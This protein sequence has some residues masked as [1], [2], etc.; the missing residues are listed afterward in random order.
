IQSFND[1]MPYDQ[2]I[3]EQLAGDLLPDATQDQRLA[4]AFN[5]L[6]RQTNEGGSVLE[7]FR[8]AYVSDRTETFGTAFL[9]LT[10][11]CARCHDHKFDPVSQENYYQLS[12]F[13]N[14][15]D[16]SGMY[17]HF[18]KAV[19]SP[20]MLLYGDGGQ[21]RHAQLRAAIVGEED[22]LAASADGA[23]GAGF[24]AWLKDPERT[25]PLPVPVV[26]LSLDTVAEGKTPD[27]AG[28]ARFATLT[29]SP[30]PVPG[31]E[32]QALLFDGDDGLALKDKAAAFARYQPVS[33]GI[34][35]RQEQIAPRSVIFHRSKAAEVAGSRGYELL[36]LDGKPTFSLC[37][38][39]PGNAIR[40][41]AKEALPV[42]TWTHCAITYDGSSRAEGV[43]LYVNG[44]AIEVNVIRDGLTKTILYAGE[45]DTPVQLA[46]RFRDSGFKGGRLDAFKVFD[47]CLTPLEVEALAGRA[48]L[49]ANLEQ[50]IA[51]GGEDGA[52][53]SYHIKAVDSGYREQCAALTAARKAEADFVAAT[54]SVMVMEETAP[55]TTYILERGAYNKHGKTVEPG[56][57]E[58]ILPMP[59]GAPRNRLG[60]AQWLCD[61]DNPLTARVAVNRLWQQCFGQGLVKTQEDFGT[62]GALPEHQ[63]VLDMLAVNFVRNGW[64]VKALLREIVMSATYRQDSRATP[65]LL[66]RDLD[67]TL[68]ARGPRSRLSAEQIRDNALASAGLLVAKV[69]GASVKPYQPEGLWEEA[70]NH[71]YTQD[72]GEGLYR[73]SLYT[74]IKRTVP[75]PSMLT[76]NATSRE[77]CLVRRES[78]VTPLQALVLLNDPQYVEAAR[79]LAATTLS[80]NTDGDE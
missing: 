24:A 23:A 28:E 50:R 44:K 39:W 12:A 74:F 1:N 53:R 41:Q 33:F 10:L 57:P 30:K 8:A 47:R 6:H 72:R 65:A 52:V 77:V 75:P 70:S 79:N 80:P 55:R 46:M 56:T 3:L 69:G 64:D 27:S 9:G 48:N 29:R 73:R 13:F 58:N 15:I 43:T 2:F 68:L 21:E 51:A 26:S 60:L 31:P 19:P 35:L 34:W 42:Q 32:G 49:V 76:F 71:T 4:T 14:N 16:E 61:P 59:A 5:R 20:S 7:E 17:S 36:L 11:N 45:A 62:Q 25:I 22:K 63:Q 38:F 54:P 66:A 40:V 18:T 37:H 67:N 78:T